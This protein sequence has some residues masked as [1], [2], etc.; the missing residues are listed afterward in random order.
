MILTSTIIIHIFP[1]LITY[2]CFTIVPR[3]DIDNGDKYFFDKEQF[4]NFG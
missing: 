2:D 1:L 3:G 4:D